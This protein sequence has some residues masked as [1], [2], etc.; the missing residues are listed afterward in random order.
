MISFRFSSGDPPNAR[1]RPLTLPDL[2]RQRVA[3]WTGRQAEGG[4]RWRPVVL[5]CCR[6]S[7][8]SLFCTGY[9]KMHQ[10][11]QNYFVLMLLI[12]CTGLRFTAIIATE[13]QLASNHLH[14]GIDILTSS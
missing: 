13:L 2:R 1:Q 14:F 11:Q 7:E 5:A 10:A 12:F 8:T 9:I 3:A 6:L 4:P